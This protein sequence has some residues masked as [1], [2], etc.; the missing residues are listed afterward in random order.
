VVAPPPKQFSSPYPFHDLFLLFG[1]FHGGLPKRWSH[2]LPAF[3]MRF[4]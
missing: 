4:L 1:E 2:A 3:R